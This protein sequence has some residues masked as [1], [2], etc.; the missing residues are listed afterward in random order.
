VLLEAPSPQTLLTLN[1][2]GAVR[3]RADRRKLTRESL[4]GDLKRPYYPRPTSYTTFVCAFAAKLRTAVSLYTLSHFTAE[5]ET[6][7]LGGGEGRLLWA[8]IGRILK[9]ARR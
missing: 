3:N 7:T 5:H 4:S 2:L 1:L 8:N 6:F 9:E